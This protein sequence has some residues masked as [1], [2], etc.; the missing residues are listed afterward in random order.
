MI[1]CGTT[2]A[3]G[4]LAKMRISVSIPVCLLLVAVMGSCSSQPGHRGAREDDSV[5]VSFNVFTRGMLVNKQPSNSFYS[6]RRG[7]YVR[8]WL[9]RALVNAAEHNVWVESCWG[10]A[11]G[12]DGRE[13][14]R[15]RPFARHSRW[16]LAIR[17]SRPPCSR[18]SRL[19][20]RATPSVPLLDTWRIAR[21][22]DGRGRSHR[23][24]SPESP[25]R[26]RPADRSRHAK[27][28][29]T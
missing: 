11:L 27:E 21:R 28:E 22:T 5:R 15:V 8:L 7:A 26:G 3:T 4:R 19:R 18:V 29:R 6:V 12:V 10:T 17:M 23:P 13:L 24:S 9:Q 25:H 16:G 14:F 20:C 2:S 1:P